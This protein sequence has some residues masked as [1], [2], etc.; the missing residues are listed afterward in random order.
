METNDIFITKNTEN[1]VVCEI[2]YG[3][4]YFLRCSAHRG[5]EIPGGCHVESGG[6]QVH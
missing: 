3:F 2:N 4:S 6:S 5:L 1:A